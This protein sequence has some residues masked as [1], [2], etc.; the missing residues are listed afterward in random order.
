MASRGGEKRPEGTDGSDFRSRTVIADRYLASAKA[1]SRL[2]AF[3]FAHYLL[4]VITVSVMV[5]S[6]SA[7]EKLNPLYPFVVSPWLLV[8]LGSSV[9]SGLAYVSLSRN[10]LSL[11]IIYIWGS[12]FLGFCPLVLNLF[13]LFNTR[14]DVNS[15][16][17]VLDVAPLP[18]VELFICI[19]GSI[20]QLGGFI[21][22]KTLRDAWMLRKDS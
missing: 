1:K 15:I 21:N 9:P 10:R 2:K 22:A 12:I 17:M 18:V 13:H 6:K 14:H 5:L 7:S 20:V 19:F 4:H 16:V 11:I 3:I 8:W